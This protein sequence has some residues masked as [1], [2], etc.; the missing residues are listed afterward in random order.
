MSGRWQNTPRPLSKSRQTSRPRGTRLS[1]VRRLSSCRRAKTCTAPC[2]GA[3]RGKPA[4]QPFVLALAG[5]QSAL[6]RRSHSA[7][8]ILTR[9]A[10]P[11]W[12][13]ISEFRPETRRFREIGQ[14]AQRG[15]NADRAPS[16]RSRFLRL[17][18]PTSSRART[19]RCLPRIETNPLMMLEAVSGT[20]GVPPAT[21]PDR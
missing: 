3:L 14:S 8:R 1:A 10:R 6:W 21:C 18:R 12:R 19:Q 2:F 11:A 5:P 7:E 9:S 13:R 16:S 4:P 20:K 17:A 15:G